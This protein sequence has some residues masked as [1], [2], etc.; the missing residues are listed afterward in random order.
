VFGVWSLAFIKCN[1]PIG[2][3]KAFNASGLI[4]AKPQTP[5]AKPVLKKAC[6]ELGKP[7]PLRSPKKVLCSGPGWSGQ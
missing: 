6:F 5:N 1:I 3:Q 4:N 2:S 7:L